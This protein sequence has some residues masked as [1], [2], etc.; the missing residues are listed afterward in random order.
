MIHPQFNPMIGPSTYVL[1]NMGA[2]FVPCMKT[3]PDIQNATEKIN[4]PCPRTTTSNPDDPANKCDLSQLCGFGGVNDE[5]PN[6]WFRFIIPMF[7]HAGIIHIGFNLMLQLTMGRE[8]EILIGSV[9]F[10]LVYLS[11]G[12]FGFV[13]GGNFAATAIAS[14]GASG[15]LFGILALTL[16]DL[17]YS[18]RERRKPARELMF[19]ILEIVVS[20]VLGLLPGLDNFSHIGGFLCGLVLGICILHSPNILRERIGL[21]TPYQPMGAR[22]EDGVR[23]FAKGPAGFFKGRKP[24]W[25]A[26]WLIRAGALVGTLVAFI[27][28]VNN[29]YKYH[30]TCSWCK[31]LSCLVSS[32]KRR[33]LEV[34][35]SIPACE[36]LVSDW[37]STQYAEV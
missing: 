18:W 14:T 19:L 32:W 13:L 1:I 10:A 5:S 15:S 37:E 11:S 8:V 28:L 29:F 23:A 30:N 27:V 20:F 16:L 7:M 2:R 34:T 6:Q 35:D 31:Y 26:W 3:V 21:S 33:Y 9:R 24:F 17:I 4:W 22:S 12:I 25:W 36:Q